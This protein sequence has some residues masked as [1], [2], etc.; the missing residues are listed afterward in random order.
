MRRLL[1]QFACLLFVASAFA[2][3]P[4]PQINLS[5]NIGCQGFPCTNSG[6]LVFASDANHTMTAQESS[7]FNIKVTS[8]VSLTTTRNLISPAGRF[9]FTIENATTGGQ[10]IQIIGPSGTGVTIPNGE[11]FSVWNDG[12]NY[13][14]STG[15]PTGLGCSA[16]TAG[17]Y[18]VATGGAACADGGI[19]DDGTTLSIRPISMTGT[20]QIYETLESTD[21]PYYG[22]GVL[23]TTTGSGN[24]NLYAGTADSGPEALILDSVY[25]AKLTT[26]HGLAVVPQIDAPG[27][28]ALVAGST[29]PTP[30]TGSKQYVQLASPATIDASYTVL[31]PSAQ[32]TGALTNDGVGNLAWISGVTSII[33]GTNL[34][35]SSTGAGGTGA[36]TINAGASGTVGNCTT[37]GALAD[38]PS[39]GTA[40]GCAA[41]PVTTSSSGALNVPGLFSFTSTTLPTLTSCGGGSP[42]ISGNENVFTVAPGSGAPTACTVN[43]SPALTKGICVAT[44]LGAADL[45]SVS[46]NANSTTAVTFNLSAATESFNAVCF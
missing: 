13:V 34:T 35:I 25:G 30:W 28:L 29:V 43:F 2:Q 3:I 12:T 16:L 39:S 10:A 5:G 11:T 46:V 32:G 42:T 9:A 17:Y 14:Q 40:V 27:S 36:V 26:Y 41:T 6:T 37:A 21:A 4:A 23:L 1:I 15:N 31:L 18:L 24:A 7:A 33:A 19:T 20:P 22:A 44:G 45:G 38:Y 8:G